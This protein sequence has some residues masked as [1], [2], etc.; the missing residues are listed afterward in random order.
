MG[1]GSPRVSSRGSDLMLSWEG[2]EIP[3][4]RPRPLSAPSPLVAPSNAS[5][6]Q[7]HALCRESLSPA[8]LEAPAP[9]ACAGCS[10]LASQPPR[11]VPACPGFSTVSP[12]S[13][14]THRPP[15][16]SWL[17]CQGSTSGPGRLPWCHGPWLNKEPA[18]PVHLRGAGGL[19]PCLGPTLENLIWCTWSGDREFALN[20]VPR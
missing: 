18:G 16:G 14:E 19:D 7:A 10:G 20:R 9:C 4:R 1:R 12:T 17:A 13:Q 2:C 15:P 11:P 8:S 3:G 5:R 6:R